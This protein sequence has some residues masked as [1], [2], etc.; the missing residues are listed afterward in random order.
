MQL[1]KK[2]GTHDGLAATDNAISNVG[3]RAVAA[4]HVAAAA[5]R[6]HRSGFRLRNR[7]R[8]RVGAIVDAADT[9]PL[10]LRFDRV[11]MASGSKAFSQ[12]P[13]AAAVRRAAIPADQIE[14]ACGLVG[15]SGLDAA[16]D[17]AAAVT[18]SWHD[19]ACGLIRQSSLAAATDAADAA[20]AARVYVEVVCSSKRP[21]LPP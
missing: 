7:A 20:D 5:A 6:S 3:D 10:A 11:E 1:Q 21:A 12:L 19:A 15:R 17:V 16:A 9:T 4:V 14:A 2:K 8:R 18:T 13:F